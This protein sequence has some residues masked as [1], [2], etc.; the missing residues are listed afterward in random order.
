[1]CR[2]VVR[3]TPVVEDIFKILFLQP[4]HCGDLVNYN[5]YVITV[6]RC[7]LEMLETL[8]HLTVPA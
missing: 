4:V 1:V 8:R 6:K 5:I 2:I 3:I 7:L